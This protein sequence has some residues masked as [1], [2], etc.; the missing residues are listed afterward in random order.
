MHFAFY[1][2]QHLKNRLKHLTNPKPQQACP[3]IWQPR[4]P[5]WAGSFPSLDFN[6]QVGFSGSA[7]MVMGLPFPGPVFIFRSWAPMHRRAEMSRRWRAGP[8]QVLQLT[9]PPPLPS[10]T[11]LQGPPSPMEERE[12]RLRDSSASFFYL[13][14]NEVRRFSKFL[15]ALLILQQVLIE[16]L[17]VPGTMLGLERHLRRTQMSPLVELMFVL[18]LTLWD[19]RPKDS[20]LC[21]PVWVAHHSSPLHSSSSPFFSS[22]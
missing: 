6:R 19:P 9:H 18:K 11:P 8:D 22:S 14:I 10:S 20:H 3:S 1:Q 13:C 4:D 15:H 17:L 16:H 5:S 2:T 12:W 21:H 7:V